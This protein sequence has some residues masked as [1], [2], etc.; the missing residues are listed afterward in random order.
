MKK[1]LVFATTAIITFGMCISTQAATGII[2]DG[3][4]MVPVRGVFEQ[5]KFSVLWDNEVGIATL[6]DSDNKV[7]IDISKND[8]YIEVNGEEQTLDVPQQ[9]I[10]GRFYIPLRAVGDALGADIS[11]DSDNKVAHISYNGNDVYVNC[12]D[13]VASVEN[14]NL[15]GGVEGIPDFGG[16]IMRSPHRTYTNDNFYLYSYYAK[17]VEYENVKSY[18]EALSHLGFEFNEKLDSDD[19]NIGFQ[20]SMYNKSTRTMVRMVAYTGGNMNG[21]FNIIVAHYTD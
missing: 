12:V 2:V 19:S 4:T 1:L 18:F 16:Y 20:Y 17:D 14:I 6:K 3:R 8:D 9:I 21:D 5:L 13:D 10:D 7:S 15:Y 11:W